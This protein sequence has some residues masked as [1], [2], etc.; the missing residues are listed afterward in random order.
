[1]WQTPNGYPDDAVRWTN[2]GA[3]TQRLRFGI[4]LAGNGIQG[5]RVELQK[6]VGD[7]IANGGKPIAAAELVDAIATRLLGKDLS[8]S[9]RDTAIAALGDDPNAA[10]AVGLLLGSPE[11]QHR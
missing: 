2:V 1:A 11:F 9:T 3:L 10:R 7:E 5:T 4:A 6:I 8:K